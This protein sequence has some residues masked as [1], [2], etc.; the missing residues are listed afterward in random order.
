MKLIA[1]TIISGVILTATSFSFVNEAKAN[2]VERLVSSL[3]ESAKADDRS[4]M[5]KKL[6]T[7]RL[8]LR[9]IYEGISCGSEGSLLRVATTSGSLEAATFIATKLGK[10]NLGVAEADGKT[11]LQYAQ[12]LVD[13]GDTSKKAFVELYQSK[14]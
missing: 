11:I 6:K 12:G 1:K 8:R 4:G 7:A 9:N 2:D 5:R 3:C 10:E 13:A 14:I